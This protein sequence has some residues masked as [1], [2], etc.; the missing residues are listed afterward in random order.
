[1]VEYELFYLVLASKKA[2]LEQIKKDVRTTVEESGGTY[3]GDDVTQ[4]RKLAY[5]IKHEWRGVYVAQRFTIK[6]RQDMMPDTDEP[7]PVDLITKKLNVYKDVV[8][9]VIVR[10]DEVPS[11]E[12]Y[13]KTVA[14]AQKQK[15]RRPR[16]TKPSSQEEMDKKLEEVLNI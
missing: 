16:G 4:E 9:F 3:K 7:H 15:T 12:Q 2:L 8:R 1:M 10:A 5:D 11:L 14:E 6:D 13:K